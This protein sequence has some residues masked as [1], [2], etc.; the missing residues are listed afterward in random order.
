MPMHPLFPSQPAAESLTEHNRAE[1]KRTLQRAIQEGNQKLVH[2]LR[3]SR[4]MQDRVH[5]KIFSYYW[6]P[7]F[8][9]AR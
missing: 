8:R 6:L 5:T 1:W 4:V 3:T 9:N 7:Y 2:R